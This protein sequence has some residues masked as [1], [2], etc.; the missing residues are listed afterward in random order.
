MLLSAAYAGTGAEDDEDA[1]LG[2]L[3]EPWSGDLDGIIERGFLRVLTV[4]NP[5]Y[6]DY[7]GFE[8]QGAAV[9]I[10]R[11]FE[12][13]LRKTLGRE[14]ASLHVVLIPVPRDR[15]LDNLTA[16]LGDIAAANLTITPERQALV[17]FSEP[18]R[19]DVH[20][21]VVT[22]PGAPEI[23]SLDG[24]ASSKTRVHVRPSS[25]YFEH[26]EALN[27]ARKKA[28][29]RGIRIEK[30]DERLEDYDLLDMVDKGVIPA[31]VVDS[32]MARLWSQIFDHIQ[33]H[34]NLVVHSGGSI[35][36]AV[37]SNNPQLLAAVNGFVK[38]AREGTLLG[39]MLARRYLEKSSWMENVLSGNSMEKYRQTIGV[40]RRYAD[41]YDFDWLM[42]TAQGYQESGLDQN[43]RSKSGAVG[44]MQVLPATAGD[45][46]VAVSGIEQL[47][48][49][50]HAGVKYLR[51]LRDRYF[52]DAGIEPLDRVLFSLAAYNAGPANIARAR[53]KAAAT[54]FDPDR[55]FG[56]VE[57]AA[58][59]T[60]S[61]EPVVYVRNIYKYY[62][63]YRGLE[64]RRG[65]RD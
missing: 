51:F 11:N 16:G 4:Y 45:R 52:S 56:H 7:F 50:I 25:S 57:V 39:N 53:K 59:R 26:L 6:F 31:V 62:V 58:A 49:N 5:L 36:W 38:T 46:N 35:A 21:V 3:N 43:K 64:E 30:A 27:K 41:Q 33:V 9:E 44:V 63:V 42:I 2:H 60:I 55:W 65:E 12:S 17:A 14:A 10:A 32:H 47:D 29:K 18:S 34:E 54:G 37:R 1:L 20:E 22:G 13:H 24:L 15:L 28:G 48:N 8:Q 61:R 19:T 23:T 40:I